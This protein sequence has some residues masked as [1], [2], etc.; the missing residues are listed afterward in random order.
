MQFALSADVFVTGEPRFH[1]CLAA[2]ARGIAL[3]LAGH[4]ATE[5]FAVEEF[6]VSIKQ[7]FGDLE[8]WAS[9]REQDPLWIV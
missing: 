9:E 3:V 2:Q 5:R 1:D 8:V 4:Y 7:A 6:A